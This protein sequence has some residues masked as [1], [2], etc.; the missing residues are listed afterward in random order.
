MCSK[1][2]KLLVQTG[3][4]ENQGL[5]KIR[6]R[7]AELNRIPDWFVFLI[8][9]RENLFVEFRGELIDT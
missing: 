8:V 9:L 6:L 2:R 7:E 5:C 1:L 4:G 3:G